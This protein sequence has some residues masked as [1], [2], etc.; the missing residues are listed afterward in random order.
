MFLLNQLLPPSHQWRSISLLWKVHLAF[1]LLRSKDLSHSYAMEREE[2]QWQWCTSLARRL[3]VTL[4]DYLMLCLK[5][6]K[7]PREETEKDAKDKGRTW[8]TESGNS[9]GFGHT[10][11][12]KFGTDSRGSKILIHKFCTFLTKLNQR[13]KVIWKISAQMRILR[14]SIREWRNNL[15]IL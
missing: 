3:T 2:N 5:G 13:L 4:K 6:D 9:S 1:L 12:R 8:C 11:G 14:D 15:I 10:P 7:S